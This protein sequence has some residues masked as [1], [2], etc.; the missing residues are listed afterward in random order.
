MIADGVLFRK[1]LDVNGNIDRK[2]VIIPRA[3]RKEVLA[4]V[5]NAILGGYFGLKKTLKK[6]KDLYYWFKMADD[7]K[8]C[9]QACKV[10]GRAKE[11]PTRNNQ[12]LC[13][14]MSIEPLERIAIDIAGPLPET[15]KRNTFI[16]VVTDYIIKCFEA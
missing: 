8:L 15:D 10:C 14:R 5:H 3:I 1:W 12:P 2:Q 9:C 7:V 11:S 4:T 6:V 16:L 13:Q